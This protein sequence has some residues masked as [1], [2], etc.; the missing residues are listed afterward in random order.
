MATVL[1]IVLFGL[2]GFP[3]L[4][5][6]QQPA[7]TLN[8]KTN[9]G[10]VGD[11]VADDAAAIQAVIHSAK[12]QGK[13]VYFPPGVYVVGSDVTTTNGV[14]LYGDHTGISIIRSAPGTVHKIGNQTWSS[15][16][17]NVDVE[18]LFFLNSELHWY[19]SES[20]RKNINVR[21][22]MFFANDSVFRTTTS[23]SQFQ[24]TLGHVVDGTV[25][26]CLF[27]SQSNC[28]QEC[29]SGYQNVRQTYRRNAF[30]MHLG[31]AQWL[32][33]EWLGYSSW[34]NLS[35]KIQT[36][37]TQFNLEDDQ[38][39]FRRNLKVNG[40]EDTLVEHNIFNGSPHTLSTPVNRDHVV[41]A[42]GGYSDL[43]ILSNW[44]RGWPSAPNGGLKIR[45]T[46]GATT[47]I[48]N[49]FVNTPILQYAYDNDPENL[50]YNHAIIHRN[51]LEMYQNFS[52]TRLGISFWETIDGIPVQ[53]NNEYSAN[54]FECPKSYANCINLT[55]GDLD[56]H[57]AYDSNVYLSDGSPVT[58][59]HSTG[60]FPLVSGAP[61]SSRT[62]AYDSYQ[63]PDLDIPTY[64]SDPEFTTSL[65]D[66]GN[67]LP[68]VAVT[69]SVAS[70]A[71]DADG[72]SL[73]F[74]KMDGPDWLTVSLDGTY[75]G[76]P[77]LADAG[78]NEFT[79]RAADNKDGYGATTLRINV[80][81]DFTTLSFLPLHDAHVSQEN[82]TLNY[83]SNTKFAIR[84]DRG[85]KGF[86][87]FM[88]F[89]AEV[90]G[91]AVV[92]AKLKFYCSQKAVTL[93]LY[94]VADTN[95]ME[96]SITW[97]NQPSKIQFATMPVALES[98]EEMDVTAQVG[99]GG[100]VGFAFSSTSLS[101][102]NIWTKESTNAP[103]LEVTV[104]ADSA[105]W[106]G[107]GLPNDWELA[108]F[109]GETNAVASGHGD[110]DGMDNLSEYIAGYDPTNSESFFVA[111]TGVDTAGFVISWN[112]VSNREYGVW[113]GSNL[114]NSF[115]N[116]AGWI[117]FPQNSYTDTVNSTESSGFYRVD[118]H[119]P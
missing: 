103:V 115:T 57:T 16:S 63:I 39:Y 76:T 48:A 33:T 118:V 105:D 100:P 70:L 18:D 14:S 108:Y 99:P 6:A 51:H 89:D 96:S 44:M 91:L 10:A 116:L 83:G 77:T 86:T 119:I 93:K 117:P 104:A 111:T 12:S 5:S 110:G 114:T 25:E 42:H 81:A 90:Q 43:V 113:H 34:S 45:N 46:P 66:L 65:V 49:Y 79:V 54:V 8:V 88:R 28:T 107:D 7:N 67:A 15:P 24:V 75:S 30:G 47:V 60:P 109:G 41:Y 35:A 85:G 72:E 94:E 31:R 87:G 53:T 84:D 22:C 92:S 23:E 102:M 98:W 38:G 68:G 59:A 21:R 17:S 2:F 106:D 73:E 71:S 13:D 11:G 55:N 61:D 69:G 74:M 36:L 32:E 19:G 27:I 52:D 64:T 37:R 95:W 82:P 56:G 29:I 26:D 97:S 40:S 58:T 50:F 101:Y 4:G 20:V 78:I 80:N 3:F 9:G 1:K 112:A 62:S